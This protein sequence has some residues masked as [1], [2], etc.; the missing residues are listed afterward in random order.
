[1]EN[2]PLLRV[3]C[4]MVG[5]LFLGSFLKL[6]HGEIACVILLVTHFFLI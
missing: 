4:L 5:I 3:E 1:M 6:T 2:E